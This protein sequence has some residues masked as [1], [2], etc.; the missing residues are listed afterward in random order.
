[1]G[2]RKACML[3]SSEGELRGS[4]LLALRLATVKTVP[5]QESETIEESIVDL[6]L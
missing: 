2:A 3:T 4:T 6:E 1:M 5:R